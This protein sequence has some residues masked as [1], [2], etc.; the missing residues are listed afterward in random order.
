MIVNIIKK[1][2]TGEEK[3]YIGKNMYTL[4]YLEKY[5]VYEN[6]VSD[7]SCKISNVLFTNL[8]SLTLNGVAKVRPRSFRIFKIIYFLFFIAYSKSLSQDLPKIL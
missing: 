3:V 1:I 2:Y 8:I 7:K 6:N 4:K 5:K